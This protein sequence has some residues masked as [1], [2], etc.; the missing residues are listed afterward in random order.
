MEKINITTIEWQAPEYTHKERSADFLWTIGLVAL[1]G[2]IIAIFMANYVFAIFIL[3]SGGCLILFTVR[4]PED[5]SFSISNDGIK[6]GKDM[7]SWKNI[8]SFNIKDSTPYDKLLIETTRKFL[9][10]YTIP[11]PSAF[12]DEARESLLKII[13]NAEIEESASMLF[14]EKLGF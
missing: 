13:P 6:M 3:V 2:A 14:M 1:V 8:K 5:I 9:P 10:I 11:M 12:S 7:H 4:P